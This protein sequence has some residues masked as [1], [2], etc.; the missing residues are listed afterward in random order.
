M[1]K[2]IV[3][4]LLVVFSLGGK[5]QDHSQRRETMK[6]IEAQKVAYITQELDLTPKESQEFWP[7]FNEMNRKLRE[8]KRKKYQ[9]RQPV[10]REDLSDEEILII[11]DNI[12]ATDLDRAKIRKEYFSKIK[13]VLPATKVF[14]LLHVERDFNRKLLGKIRSKHRHGRSDK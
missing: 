8:L 12:L 4:I 7:I 3:V 13:N 5:S 6:K 10:K 11:C 2:N 14:K 1:K 9:K